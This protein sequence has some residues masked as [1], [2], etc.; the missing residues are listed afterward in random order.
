MQVK[1]VKKKKNDLTKSLRS[2]EK[3]EKMIEIAEKSFKENFEMKKK[4]FN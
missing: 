4:K 2:V 3:C 1:N